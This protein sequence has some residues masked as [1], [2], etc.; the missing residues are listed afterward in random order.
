MKRQM[1]ND[2]QKIVEKILA[3]V[4]DD[5]GKFFQIH[6]RLAGTGKPTFSLFYLG[7]RGAQIPLVLDEPLRTVK[8]EL[9]RFAEAKTL[10]CFA[11][12]AE[13]VGELTAIPR[14]T[15]PTLKPKTR[16]FMSRYCTAC[17]TAT[18]VRFTRKTASGG[19]SMVETM[20]EI[21]QDSTEWSE[22]YSFGWGEASYKRTPAK[23]AD[24]CRK[25]PSE[26]NEEAYNRLFE[27]GDFAVLTHIPYWGGVNVSQECPNRD[28]VVARLEEVWKKTEVL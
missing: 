23:I 16:L 8:S 26:G 21:T 20:H 13:L 6:Q 27:A 18:G 22:E 11:Y 15:P 7:L 4:G 5:M 17:L 28:E 2:S 14:F 12:V 19:G 10:T 9:V 25:H 3:G 24:A 1:I